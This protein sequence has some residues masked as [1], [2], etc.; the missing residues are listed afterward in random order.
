MAAPL[1]KTRHPGI[2][3]RGSRWVV[4]YRVNGAAKK[5]SARTLDEARKLKAARV[6]DVARGEFQEASRVRF[7]AYAEEWIDRYQGRGSGFRESTREDYRRA[8]KNWAYPYFDERLRRRTLSQITPHDLAG[9]VAWLVEQPSRSGGPLSDS[10]IRNI[11]NPVRAC[12][13]SAVREG[14]IRHNPAQGVALPH[15][16]DV[17]ALDQDEVRALTREQLAVFLASVDPRYRTLFRLLASTGLRVSEAFALR[18]RDLVLDGSSPRVKVRR[19]IVRGRIQPP[20]SRHGR[21]DVPL[22]HELADELRQRRRS[23][24]W[25][26]DDDLVFPSGAGTPLQLSNVRRRIL[27][28]AAEE[29]GAPWAGFHTFRH[30]CASLLFARGANAKVVQRWLGHHSAAFTLATYVHLLSDDLGEPIDLQGE[31][32]RDSTVPDLAFTSTRSL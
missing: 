13:A 9:F 1:E 16:P 5:E 21:R 19:A 6:A 22:D 31:L 30:T 7:R 28:P 10:S 25:P 4:T 2:Y 15:R 14:L 26:G 32:T 3:R 24:E 17:D 23:S 12:L 18:W 20:K 8:L 11:L 27:A 29:A